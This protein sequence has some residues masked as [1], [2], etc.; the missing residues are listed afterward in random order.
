MEIKNQYTQA[1]IP[2][3]ILPSFHGESQISQY[4]QAALRT[5]TH[6]G[7]P[8]EF[9]IRSNNGIIV[10]FLLSHAPLRGFS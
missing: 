4:I 3:R 10:P 7:G 9:P 2:Y 8:T 5:I 6:S 1:S